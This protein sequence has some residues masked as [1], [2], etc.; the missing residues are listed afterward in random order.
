MKTQLDYRSIA[1]V[2]AAVVL[3]GCGASKQARPVPAPTQ[4]SAGPSAQGPSTLPAYSD[5]QQ[6]ILD[7]PVEVAIEQPATPVYPDLQ[8]F[9]FVGASAVPD[10]S[11]LTGYADVVAS[12]LE[13]SPLLYV[14]RSGPDVPANVQELFG[15]APASK[16]DA[17]KR[18]ANHQ[19]QLVLVDAPPP[20]AARALMEQGLKEKGAKRL[21]LLGKA[22]QQAG[23][24]PGVH[25][26]LAESAFAE[27]D[28]ALADKAARDALRIDSM[29]PGAYRVLAEVAL[30]AGKRDEARSHIAKALALYPAYDRGWELARALLNRPLSR[31][32]AVPQP[33]IAVN[34]DGAVIV[35]S[36]PGAFC[37]RYAACKAAFRYEPPLRAPILN[38]PVGTPYHLSATEEVVCTHAGLGA[39][40]HAQHEGVAMPD[41][42]AEMLLQLARTQGVAGFAMFEHLGPHRPELFRVA[43]QPSHQAVLQYVLE[44]VLSD[45]PVQAGGA[46]TAQVR[47][48]S[49]FGA[50]CLARR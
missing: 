23:S 21:E 3:L 31:E 49:S 2:L 26:L 20:N 50:L 39:H 24:S 47:P 32:A 17:W 38:E 7:T 33:F 1:W 19:G 45:A 11:F 15:P 34:N 48:S 16:P 44:R 27:G 41:P 28:A 13:E 46:V 30:R 25:L 36:C 29:Y 14:F 40:L 42:R 43:P 4:A 9:T 10:D 5:R 12:T 18:A 37:E 35:A 22:A 6:Q 8:R